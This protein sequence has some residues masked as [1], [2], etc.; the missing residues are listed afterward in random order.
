M[1]LFRPTIRIETL[2]VLKANRFAYEQKFHAGLNVIRGENSSG[3]STIL[4]FLFFGLGGDFTDFNDDALR[5]DAVIIEIVVNGTSRLLLRRQISNSARR[6]M[7]VAFRPFTDLDQISESEWM[8][9][10]FQRARE[11]ES[12]SQMLFRQIGFPEARGEAGSN[13]TMHQLLRLIYADQSSQQQR[14]FRSEQFDSALI[15]ETVGDLFLGAFDDELY[16]LTIEHDSKQK[17]YQLLDGQLKNLYTFLGKADASLSEMTVSAERDKWKSRQLALE[18]SLHQLTDASS[19]DPTEGDSVRELATELQRLSKR[20]NGLLDRREAITL[21]L[22]DSEAF[23]QEIEERLEAIGESEKFHK[24]LGDFRFHFCPACFSEVPG[25]VEGDKCHLCKQPL[26]PNGQVTVARMANELAIQKKESGRLREIRM[27]EL[28]TIE[29][30]LGSLETRLNAQRAQYERIRSNWIGER[31]AKIRLV[32]EEIGYA[33]RML[34]GI[35]ESGHLVSVLGQI[36]QRISE[37]GIL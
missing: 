34:E 25:S 13:I 3:K 37:L 15:R 16:N 22:A 11:R 8:R 24:L 4:N 18:Q 9:Y 33:R 36:Q 29:A 32:H 20:T 31:D 17:E 23:V 5:C 6:S 7:D 35:D 27:A 14:I 10:P 12:F 21:A 30:E 26:D 28:Q 2:A 1:T 19:A